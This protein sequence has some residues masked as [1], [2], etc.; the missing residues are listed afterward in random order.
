LKVKR[1]IWLAGRRSTQKILKIDIMV[2][3]V[4]GNYDN[5]IAKGQRAAP[6]L[7]I[8]NFFKK[9]RIEEIY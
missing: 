2:F 7:K 9:N 3:M 8:F 1:L 5:K 6:P 4:M